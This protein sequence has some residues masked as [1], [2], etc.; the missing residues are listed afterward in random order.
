MFVEQLLSSYFF[1]TAARQDKLSAGASEK[2]KKEMV[3]WVLNSK[4]VNTKLLEE[5]K[6]QIP[7]SDDTYLKLRNQVI[8]TKSPELLI[9][10]AKYKNPNDIELIKSF[11]ED[12]FLAIEEFPDEKFLSFLDSNIEHSVR[13]PFMFALSGICSEEAKK[14]VDKAI[15]F[16]KM[17]NKKNDCGNICLSIIYQQIDKNKCKVFYPSLENLWLTDKI[18]SFDVID[19][20]EKS[21]SKKETEDFIMKGFLQEGEPEIIVSNMYALDNMMDNLTSDLNFDSN[22]RLVKL[23][24]K[25]KEFSE[26]SY[27]MAVRNALQNVDDLDSDIL[28]RM[29][30]NN[31]I[32]LKNKDVLL[33][34]LRTNKS[35]YGLL[36]I[37]EGIKHLNDKSLFEEGVRIVK[38][39]KKEFIPKWEKFYREFIRDNHLIDN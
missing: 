33:E 36:S 14:I 26:E 25:I 6:Y 32:V 13:F 31:E 11:G 34:R 38:S 24:K 39:R 3:D 4:P 23:L 35:A 10:L 21:H 20:Y 18:I 27:N 2:L 1:D 37:M 19:H 5:I 29:I 8:E 12:A 9:A 15:E 16:K 22:L 28:I 7:V 17:D 30:N